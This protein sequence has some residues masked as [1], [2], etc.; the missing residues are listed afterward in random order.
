MLP[1][2]SA[3]FVLFAFI[4]VHALASQV[5]ISS[6]AIGDINA[7]TQIS[8]DVNLQATE[9]ISATYLAIEFDPDLLV[10][11]G[12]GNLANNGSQFIVNE[13]D[14]LLGRVFIAM[15]SIN[16]PF[17]IG[18]HALFTLNFEAGDW[19]QTK[20]TDVSFSNSVGSEVAAGVTGSPV[21]L[22][23]I[24]GTILFNETPRGYPIEIDATE[25]QPLEILL[26][27]SDPDGGVIDYEIM[28]SPQHGTLTGIPPNLI[29]QPELSYLGSDSFYYQ[30]SD[31]HSTSNPIL[32]DIQILPSAENTASGVSIELQGDSKIIIPVGEGWVDPGA[33]A[34]DDSGNPLPVEIDGQADMEKIG[35]YTLTYKS[36]SADGATF[37]SVRRL[38]D[39]IDVNG[40]I[41]SLNGATSIELELGEPY[42]EQGASALDEEEGEVDVSI[43][44]QVNT[45]QVGEYILTYTAVDSFENEASPV[46]RLVLVSDNTP[47]SVA[48]IGP[49]QIVLEYGDTFQDEGFEAQDNSGVQPSMITEGQVNGNL[50][51]SYSVYY[52]ARDTSN[53]VSVR[54][55]RIVTV[56]DS[57]PPEI[58]LLGERTPKVAKGSVY[59]DA[60]A[61]ANDPVDGAIDVE[62]SGFVDTANPGFYELLYKAVDRHGNSA[63]SVS[64]IVTV[65]QATSVNLTLI[66]DPYV[67]IQLGSGFEDPGVTSSDSDAIIK[68]SGK[69]NINVPGEYLLTYTAS[70]G[71]D[72]T[73]DLIERIVEV[74]DKTSPVIQLKGEENLELF[75]NDNFEDPGVIVT[76]NYDSSPFL[77]TDNPVDTST[78]GS[79][80]ITYTASDTS[81]NTVT[82]TRGVEIIPR[83]DRTPPELTLNGASVVYLENGEAFDDPGVTVT[84]NELNLPFEKIGT[85]DVTKNGNYVI[86]YSAVDSAGNK[87]QTIERHVVV[88]PPAIAQLSSLD[89]IGNPKLQVKAGLVYNDPG[90]IAI[91]PEGNSISFIREGSVDTNTP[92]IYNLTYYIT[93]ADG[94]ASISKNREV[95][96]L[97][98]EYSE[99]PTIELEGSDYM[100]L[101][102][103]SQFVDPGAIALDVQDG[104]VDLEITGFVNTGS[105]GIYQLVY[106]ATDKDGNKAESVVRTVE[107][108]SNDDNALPEIELSGD[109]YI[110]LNVGDS[111]TDPGA[112]ASDSDGNNVPVKITGTVDTSIAALNILTY[113]A[114]DSLGNVAVPRVRLVTVV[115]TTPFIP[116]S[117]NRS[118]AFIPRSLN[119]SS[120]WM[121][122]FVGPNPP[123][124]SLYGDILTEH[125]LGEVYIDPGAVAL[126]TGPESGQ[127]VDVVSL[128]SVNH[129]M[130]GFYTLVYTAT[131]SS[132]S[133][134]TPKF[135]IVEVT[136]QSPPSIQINGSLRVEHEAGVPYVD[137]PPTVVDN[138]DTLIEITRLGSVDE[139]TLGSYTLTYYAMDVAGNRASPVSRVVNVV[140]KKKPALTISGETFVPHE[141]GVPFDDPGAVAFDVFEGSLQVDVHGFVNVME[142]GIYELVYS[143]EDSSGNGTV[144]SRRVL[145]RDTIPPSITILGDVNLSHR[146]GTEYVDLGVLANDSF[147][148]A[149]EYTLDGSVNVDVPGTYLCEYTAFD[150][151]GNQSFASRKIT[152]LDDLP[153]SL[154]MNGPN[155]IKHPYGTSYEDAYV[156]V[157]DNYDQDVLVSVSGSVNPAKQGIYQIVYRAADNQGNQAKPLSRVVLVADLKAP[158]ISLIGKSTIQHQIGNIY[159]DDGA[160]ITDDLDENLSVEVIGEVD[161][162]VRGTYVISYKGSDTSGNKAIEKSRLIIVDDYQSP[163]I[164]LLGDMNI[165]LATGTNFLDPG[166]YAWDETDGEINVSILGEVDQSKPGQYE[167]NYIAVDSSGNFS[168][169]ISRTVTIENQD[170]EPPSILLIGASAMDI[171]LGS[172]FVEPGW[173]AQDDYDSNVNVDV[174]GFVDSSNVGDYILTY[175]ASDNSGNISDPQSRTVSVV[176]PDQEPPVVLLVGNTEVEHP[177]GMPYIDGGASALDDNDGPVD[178]L[179]TGEVNS[180]ELGVHAIRFSATD[181]AG[182]KSKPVIRFVTVVDQTPPVISLKGDDH[183]FIKLNQNYSEPGFIITD[184][185]DKNPSL[186]ITG[187]VN[188]TKAGDYY[189][190]YTTVDSSGNESEAVQRLVTVLNSETDGP[191]IQLNGES[192]IAIEIGSLFIDD[193]AVA[194]DAPDG[195]LPVTVI[196]FVDT[197]TMGQYTLSY[198]AEDSDGNKAIPA[199]REVTV[200]DT[201]PPFIQLSGKRELALELGSIFR[202]PGALVTDGGDPAPALQ[203]SGN[204]DTTRTGIYKLHYRAF[205]AAGNRSNTLIRSVEVI[206][207]TPP[208]ITLIGASNLTIRQGEVFADPGVSI[209]D[210]DKALKASILGSV[211]TTKPG[212]YNLTYQA[213]DLSGNRAADVYRT[214]TVLPPRD[215]SPPVILIQ[216]P[217]EIIQEAGIPYIDPGAK[218]IDDIDGSLP[219]ETI[220]SVNV[221][222]PGSYQITYI[223]KDLSG[224]E[225]LPQSRTVIIEDNIAPEIV[226]LG[227]TEMHL[228]VGGVFTDPGATAYDK[229]DGTCEVNKD[230]IAILDT[231]GTYTLTYSSKDKSGNES[232][233]NRYLIVSKKPA[234]KKVMISEEVILENNGQSVLS[235]YSVNQK[236][237]DL[238]VHLEASNAARLKF[239]PNP[240]LLPAGVEFAEVKIQANDDQ[241]LNPEPNTLINVQLKSSYGVM[242]EISIDV[243]DDEVSHT[244]VVQDGYISG[245]MVF[246]DIN[247]NQSR[248]KDEPFS[249]TDKSGK[250]ALNLPM[251]KFDKNKDGKLDLVDGVLVSAGGI[252]TATGIQMKNNLV[253]T[254]NSL[255][256]NPLTTLVYH[257]LK[258][259][260]DWS[261]S[262]AMQGVASALQIPVSI[263]ILQ[264]DYL[265]EIHSGNTFALI[266]MTASVTLQNTVNMVGTILSENESNIS[267]D[268][269]D[270]V[271]DAIA[272]NT[273]RGQEA[274]LEKKSKI[275]SL[276]GSLSATHKVE[277]DENLLSLSSKLIAQGNELVINTRANSS[278]PLEIIND[279]S[280]I[281]AFFHSEANR[282]LHLAAQGLVQHS[283]VLAK[284]NSPELGEKIGRLPVSILNATSHNVGEF[285][286]KSNTH[287]VL[288]DGVA[289]NPVVVTRELSNIGETDLMIKVDL[290]GNAGEEDFKTLSAVLSFNNLEMSKIFELSELIEN[291][292]VLEQAE[293]FKLYLEPMPG[294]LPVPKFANQNYTEIV[295]LDNDSTGDFQIAANSSSVTVIEGN[296][297]LHFV[298]IERSKGTRGPAD[299]IITTTPFNHYDSAVNPDIYLVQETI[300]FDDGQ[301]RATFAFSVQDDTIDEGVEVYAIN[302]SVSEKTKAQTDAQIGLRDRVNLTIIDNDRDFPPVINKMSDKII[303]LGSPIPNVIFTVNDDRTDN[304]H[305]SVLIESSNH[306]LFPP[307]GLSY[308]WRPD[309]TLSL[310]L[311]PEPVV[312]GI[313][314]IVVSVFDGRHWSSSQFSVSVQELKDGYQISGIP[315]MI[316]CDGQSRVFPFDLI[317]DIP[318]NQNLSF[319][320]EADDQS[321]INDGHIY[322]S[323]NDADENIL[324]INKHLSANGSGRFKI[325]AT[326][327]FGWF[328]MMEFDV[329]FTDNHDVAAIPHLEILSGNDLSI[330]WDET[331]QL[332]YTPHLD[333]SFQKLPDA[334]S[335]MIWRAEDTGF[336][337]LMLR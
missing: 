259:N 200:E 300:R 25:S 330:S 247:G 301:E 279:T 142:A 218:A 319:Y 100:I 38:V 46:T 154:V 190:N 182:N 229:V 153:P 75:L 141:L 61:I 151:A 137:N 308:E 267:S 239:S 178:V 302:I 95:E 22:S 132:G 203:V 242:S 220:G 23:L 71:N 13:N 160:T 148:G 328:G 60:G 201:I 18:N 87:S 74:K 256:I 236:D 271:F 176:N 186:I 321:F 86:A 208:I 81:G 215:V 155:F 165:T 283:D 197:R 56:R 251:S 177:Y 318:D 179:I 15:A 235:I 180:N 207:V 89:L 219:L 163:S 80:F 57:K 162:N 121:P 243:L 159:T 129:N 282:D 110:N 54:L 84:D 315:S 103:Q 233:L 92:G 166:A 307:Q 246:F 311:I 175:I 107:I 94:N 104:E 189:L 149:I 280:R 21:A 98:F 45:N 225:A 105:E 30:V 69:V 212:I 50:V 33:L 109:E 304:E 12:V 76:D 40:P 211:D 313:S 128:G 333:E 145:V 223:A 24:D 28:T 205:D 53:N 288:E 324:I 231:P 59:E 238:L 66:G 130:V 291:D 14:K 191:V 31:E 295:I 309:S 245:A 217:S 135:R 289:I 168:P 139:N 123:E 36:N 164:E 116:L 292:S 62:M 171:S 82:Q 91:D 70:F 157:S 278:R 195:Q 310:T 293:S 268:I 88:K 298:T 257:C 138:H 237:D 113:T 169:L 63:K 161:V 252:D 261:E 19:A 210:Y 284:Y 117:L 20:T 26:S 204:V 183:L 16:Q 335:P 317:S 158:E 258:E 193:G 224:N 294:S 250:Y 331:Y 253:T 77:T 305:I 290:N 185:A 248:D 332:Y 17:S 314:K 3:F 320:L 216:G 241:V 254:P 312:K 156:T 9:I 287:Q 269:F 181:K 262:D 112:T 334:R 221:E 323:K 65:E 58:I 42:S 120:K 199:I 272:R 29:Y 8:L 127:S 47:P 214:V 273:I 249:M 227:E 209:S 85:V 187:Q 255:V 64:R 111:Y 188:V 297:Q 108:I 2:R 303:E 228:R 43:S 244:G 79:Y 115:A 281:Q 96:V 170:T 4:N 122:R 124:I 337:K 11:D 226:L 150:R 152:V 275:A 196:G 266:P 37:A 114:V 264:Y 184:D 285:S 51:G 34:F 44:G 146:V 6:K 326:D 306:D 316:R 136:D 147:D 55:V 232:S 299:L 90:A 240:V 1:I 329:E 173:I 192:E 322:I 134:A 125:P 325:V 286:F 263:D 206:D 327:I 198:H 167:L 7:G 274:G 68:T 72:T 143:A 27:G 140:D 67:E 101:T 144:A 102:L 5:Q 270:S 49:G 133:Q 230:G 276:L 48:L 78:L 99:P 35:N 194:V 106:S 172:E 97:S 52:S 202:D 10:F 296:K 131:D 174:I 119:R 73:L 260:P 93:D 39:V 234:I 118:S 41:V 213:V 336:F 83:P 126:D 265:K 222:I 32:V 277:I